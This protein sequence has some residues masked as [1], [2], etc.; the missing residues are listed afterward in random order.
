MAILR[1]THEGLGLTDSEEVFAH[2]MGSLST[3]IRNWEYFVNWDK[4]FANTKSLEVSLN[5]WNYL[6]GKAD[7]DGEFRSLLAQYPDIVRAIPS[8]IV[9]DGRASKAYQLL[10]PDGQIKSFDFSIPADTPDKIDAALEFVKKS[11]LERIFRD[12]GVRS[13]VDYLIGVEAGVDSNGRKNR[14]GSAMES[15][16]AGFVKD[17]C[18]DLKL[19][20]LQEA[21]ARTIEATWGSTQLRDFPLRRFDFAVQARSSVV[22][23]ETNFYGAGGS[24]L[25]SVA[26]EF[27]ELEQRLKNAGAPL[28]W[29]TDGMGW[30]TTARPLKK[31][32]D[33]LDNVMNLHLV[34]KGL[35]REVL[36]SA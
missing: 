6:L 16:V 29:I 14:G 34:S 21:S 20:Y 9:R 31:A 4:V 24:K 28:I 22:V 36:A 15:I 18:N 17:V 3:G 30:V 5:L 35:L 23:I 11:G 8:L 13:L 10:Q 25:K 19:D 32:F 26:G 1:S 27:I 2:L 33:Q 7:F 12:D